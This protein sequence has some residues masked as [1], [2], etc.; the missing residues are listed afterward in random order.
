MGLGGMGLVGGFGMGNG[1]MGLPPL[2]DINNVVNRSTILPPMDFFI[3][4][5]LLGNFTGLFV[6]LIDSSPSLSL[7]FTANQIKKIIPK[8]EG[9]T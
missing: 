2:S 8:I 1:Q 3:F 9:C 4:L 6:M 5:Y 7:L